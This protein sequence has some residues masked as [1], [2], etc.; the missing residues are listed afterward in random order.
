VGH[1]LLKRPPSP[2]RRIFLRT[3]RPAFRLQAAASKVTGL[4]ACGS[5]ST[6][7]FRHSGPYQS[8]STAATADRLLLD[9]ARAIQ[10]AGAS[11]LDARIQQG[12]K[13]L[14]TDGGR[15]APGRGREARFCRGGSAPLPVPVLAPVLFTGLRQGS[16]PSRAKTPQRR[17]GLR[18][19]G[20][21]AKP[22]GAPLPTRKVSAV[23]QKRKRRIVVRRVGP[24]REDGGRVRG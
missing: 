16:K 14:A 13:N 9:I 11:N 18:E 23:Q 20:A 4:Q 22:A 21:Q 6:P 3:T 8:R 5:N 24:F 10:P 2:G 7:L 12:R 1:H 19:P 15:D 17:L